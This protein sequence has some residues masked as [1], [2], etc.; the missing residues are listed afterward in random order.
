MGNTASLHVNLATATAGQVEILSADTPGR[1]TLESFNWGLADPWGID[2][3]LISA[4]TGPG[5]GVR[6]D[7][8]LLRRSQVAVLR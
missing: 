3:G 4:P 5:L 2:R 6:F 1:H 7:E 8:D